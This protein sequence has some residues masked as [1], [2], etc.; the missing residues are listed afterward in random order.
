MPTVWELL[1]LCLAA[2]AGGAVNAV[3]GG[4][5]LITFPVLIWVLGDTVPGNLHANAT[6]TFALF[7]GSMAGMWGYRREISQTRRWLRTL[8]PPSIVGGILGAYLT[9]YSP[10]TFRYLVPWLIL[11][12]STLFLMQPLIARWTGIGQPHAAPTTATMAGIVLLQFLIAVYG[13]YFGAG[14]GI[15]MLSGLALMGM[16]DI[17]QMNGLKTVLAT[18][19]NGLAVAIYILNGTVVWRY[20]LPMTIAA[21][22]GG[23]LG[24]A[25]A[26]QLNRVVVRWIVIAIGIG[27]SAYYFWKTNG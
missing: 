27:L 19:I 17:H 5:T 2:A 22:A 8:M 23:F 21:I 9:L 25:T 11:T 3:A 6:S 10:A 13:G 16:A 18:A 24:A 4:G 1:W 7:P 26:R 14:I 15:L 12:A 20:A